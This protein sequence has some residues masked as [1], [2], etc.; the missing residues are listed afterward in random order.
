MLRI[1]K[2]QLLFM[3]AIFA[4]VSIGRASATQDMHFSLET[5]SEKTQGHQAF[6]DFTGYQSKPMEELTV[7]LFPQFPMAAKRFDNSLPNLLLANMVLASGSKW[8]KIIAS[9]YELAFTGK[10]PHSVIYTAAMELYNERDHLSPRAIEI[11]VE[12]LILSQVHAHSTDHFLKHPQLNSCHEGPFQIFRETHF[13]K[14]AY[15][16]VVLMEKYPDA[17]FR[18]LSKLKKQ[19]SSV[20]VLNTFPLG[21]SPVFFENYRVRSFNEFDQEKVKTAV[22]TLYD[23]FVEK[24]NK[25]MPHFDCSDKRAFEFDFSY[26]SDINS[27]D[28]WD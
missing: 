3:F 22:Y 25:K 21:F 4:T 28:W 20:H 18:A 16:N 9:T 2:T 11:M 5:E 15:G 1:K 24:A 23:E 12:L 26:D 14:W 7:K 6:T 17:C 13:K 8:E 19:A 27:V 10:L